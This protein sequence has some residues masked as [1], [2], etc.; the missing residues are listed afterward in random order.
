[1]LIKLLYWLSVVV[2]SLILVIALI[3]FF[4]SRDKSSLGGSGASVSASA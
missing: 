3:M 4:E 2:I 1:M